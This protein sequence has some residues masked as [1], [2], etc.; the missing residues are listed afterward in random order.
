MVKARE[1]D[2]PAAHKYFSAA[3]IGDKSDRE[4][5]MADLEQL[6]SRA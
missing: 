5:L 3:K 6:K 1:F 4:L 2:V